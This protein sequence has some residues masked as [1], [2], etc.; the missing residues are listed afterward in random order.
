MRNAPPLVLYENI[1]G[2]VPVVIYSK[3]QDKNINN[4]LEVIAGLPYIQGPIIL[5]IDL[6]NKPSLETPSSSV[7]IT[8]HKFSFSL[9]SPSQNCGMSLIVTPFTK[10]DISPIFIE[11]LMSKIK[12]EIPLTNQSP[13]LSIEEVYQALGQGAEWAVKKFEL[14]GNILHHI[15]NRGSLLNSNEFSIPAIDHSIPNEII[16]ISQRRFGIIGGGNHFFEI[17][18]VNEIMNEGIA[19]EWGLKLNQIVIMFHSGSDALGAYLGRLYAFRKKTNIRHQLQFFKK[20]IKH[21]LMHGPWQSIPHRISY[22]LLPTAFRFID[23]ETQE[24]KRA[25][26][27]IK[28]AANFGFA[29]RIAIFN[30]ISRAIKNISGDINNGDI[31]LLYDCSHNSIYEETINGKVVWAHR[32]N[33]CQALPASRL[34]EHPIFSITGQPVILPGTNQTSSFICAAGEGVVKTHFTVDHGL[35]SI[36][37]HYEKYALSKEIEDKVSLFSYEKDGVEKINR[38]SDTAVNEAVETLNRFDIVN[39]VARL[40]PLATLKGPKS[41]IV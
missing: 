9:T 14:P 19:K 20:K 36:Q 6:H 4:K 39:T 33:A 11:K 38:F 24:G 32:H 41:R 27:T 29:C 10:E 26:L 5:L 40:K 2:K 21:H 17:Q 7:V 13:I 16:E 12:S 37:K 35:G 30:T 22:Y 25:L 3:I 23:P 8:D 15:E 18:V 31:S 1:P 28:C 34:K